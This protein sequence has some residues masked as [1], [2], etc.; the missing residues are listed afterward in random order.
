MPTVT[1]KGT[2]YSSD[3]VG[4]GG[5]NDSSLIQA[6]TEADSLGRH[7]PFYQAW[8]EVLPATE[9]PLTL[10]VA[11]GDSI[12]VLIEETAL[13]TWYMG[14]TDARTGDTAQRIVSYVS[15]G[16]SVEAIHE[17]PCLRE[18]CS[19]HLAKLAITTNVTMDPGLF[20][21]TPA[22]NSPVFHRLLVPASG[23]TLFETIMFKNAK[24]VLATP[25]APDADSDG[26]TV[27]DGKVAPPA[28]RT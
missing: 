26:F 3:W 8:T 14:V 2:M 23:A 24:K 7:R 6:G 11:P 5:V 9:D 10:D 20:S 18:P 17:R 4:I 1:A 22:S 28:P 27:A 19:K 25:S 13:N 15:S 12:H 16:A 21:S